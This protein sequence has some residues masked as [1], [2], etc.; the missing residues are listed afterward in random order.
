M[1]KRKGGKTEEIKEKGKKEIGQIKGKKKTENENK[2][3]KTAQT[4]QPRGA[5]PFPELCCR[6]MAAPH[7]ARSAAG[8]KRSARAAPRGPTKKRGRAHAGLEEKLTEQRRPQTRGR[9]RAG[10][11]T[12]PPGL[13]RAPRAAQGWAA[14]QGREDGERGHTE[15]GRQ[16]DRHTSQGKGNKPRQAEKWAKRAKKAIQ[17]QRVERH[18]L[19]VTTRQQVTAAPGAHTL[20]EGHMQVCRHPQSRAAVPSRPVPPRP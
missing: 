6:P 2:I 16:G 7:P 3:N 13:G 20:R 10:T 4:G 17:P 18:R 15:R 5:A 19:M 14:G 12:H 9:R 8:Q 11:Q 1:L